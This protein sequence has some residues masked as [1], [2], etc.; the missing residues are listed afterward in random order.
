MDLRIMRKIIIILL[1]LITFYLPSPAF[2]NTKI[3]ARTRPIVIA[4]VPKSLDNPVFIDAKEAAELTARRLNVVVEWVG[5]FKVDVDAQIR[6]VE[7]LIRRKVDGIAISCSDGERLR[8]VIDKAVDA[9]IKVATMDAD[10]P[11]SRRLFYCGTD[12]YRAGL[13]CGEAM[14]RIV[15]KKGK[16]D[17]ELNTAILTGGLTA[18]NLNERIQ[19]FKS[20]TANRIKLNYQALLTCDDDTTTATKEVEAYIKKHPETEVFF[21]AGG[22][23]FFGPSESMPLYYDWCQKGGIAVSMDT[24]Y[25]VL[26]AAEKGFVQSLVGQDF[27]KMGEFTV[28]YLVCAIKDLPIPSTFIDTGLELADQTNFT[29]LLQTKKPWDIK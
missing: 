26:Q 4:I 16:A 3:A 5:P 10:A 21:F 11:G 23:A 9:G 27:R 1:F 19:G 24:F 29:Q 25:P 12:N 22:W 6:I 13:A 8:E 28:S 7:G 17:Q 20:A 15:T 2:F 14:V 18:H